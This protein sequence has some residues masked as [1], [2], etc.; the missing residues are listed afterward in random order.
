MKGAILGDIIGSR[1][2]RSGIKTTEFD[3]FSVECRFTDDTVLTVAIAE[4]ILAQKDYAETVQEYALRYPDAGYG[5]TFKK[6]MHGEIIGPYNS[7]G[8]G[9]AMR[10]S[11]VGWL[12]NDLETVRT[13]A[14]KSAAIT[15]DH[16]EGIKGAEAIA[17]AIFLLRQGAEKEDIRKYVQETFGYNLRRT[18]EEIRPDYR[19]DVSCQGSVPESIIAFL[20][21]KDLVD[22]IR[23]AISLGG[24]TDT[25]AAM[26]A[27]LAEPF[28]GGVPPALEEVMLAFLPNDF[29]DVMHRF[30]RALQ[31]G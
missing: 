17:A 5:G 11:P 13:E 4:A 3:L 6:W 29:V 21:S 19:F 9:S 14:R 31:V 7:W 1:F 15:H 24:D 27:S 16:P 22:A 25:Q 20:D 30:E 18:V 26:A 10:V 2:E 28:Y 23:L 8:N 12:F